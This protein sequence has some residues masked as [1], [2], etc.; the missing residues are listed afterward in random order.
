M[1]LAG[2]DVAVAMN[3]VLEEANERLKVP[4]RQLYCSWVHPQVCFARQEILL[5]LRLQ[6]IIRCRV[7]I[8]NVLLSNVGERLEGNTGPIK[9]NMFAL[10][11]NFNHKYAYANKRQ[12][13]QDQSEV[14]DVVD[15]QTGDRAKT[16]HMGLP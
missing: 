4:L 12:N 7:Q 10:T 9:C 16:S 3:L 2:E 11:Y 5:N 6:V 8:H 13:L 1:L 14:S 15:E